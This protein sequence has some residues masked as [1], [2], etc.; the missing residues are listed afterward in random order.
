M[1]AT[2]HL[3]REHQLLRAHLR[4]LEVAMQMVPEAPFV[5]GEMCWSLARMLEDHIWHEAEALRPY[6]GQIQGLM[7]ARMARDHADQQTIL[8]DVNVLLVVKI[9]AP[10]SQVILPLTHLIDE[11]REHMDEEEC[12]LFPMVDRIAEAR[13]QEPGLADDAA[14]GQDHCEAAKACEEVKTWS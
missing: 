10:T 4:L 3:R 9:N 1:G 8:R 2:E 5:L 14:G 13:P 11:L 12:E 6:S 7:Q